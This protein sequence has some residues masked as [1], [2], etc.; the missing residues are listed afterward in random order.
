MIYE[1]CEYVAAP[2]ATERLHRRFADSRLDLF[3]RHGMELEG[4]WHARDEPGR[5]VYM[6]PLADEEARV[7]AW[8]AFRSDEEW[9]RVKSESEAEG[10]LVDEQLSLVL[11]NPDYGPPR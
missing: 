7:R 9:L 8:A 4:F 3:E 6:M 10:R 2:G 1:L 11:L 5:I